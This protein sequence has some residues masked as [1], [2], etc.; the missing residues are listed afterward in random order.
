MRS[1]LAAAAQ[2]E[3]AAMIEVIAR[4]WAQNRS[5]SAIA[6]SLGVWRGKVA[7]PIDRARKADS[8]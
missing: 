2:S 4:L 3:G 6:E 1:R 7:G 8:P 5:L